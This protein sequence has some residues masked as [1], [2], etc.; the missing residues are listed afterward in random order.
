MLEIPAPSGC[1]ACPWS[2]SSAIIRNQ[3]GTILMDRSVYIRYWHDDTVNI[4]R[5]Y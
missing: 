3:Q 2:A 4:F 1:S 5:V